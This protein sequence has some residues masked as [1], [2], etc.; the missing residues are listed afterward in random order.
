MIK[1]EADACKGELDITALGPLTNIA[2]A[3][4][5]EIKK[6]IKSITIMGGSA[7]AGNVTPNAEFN[8][9]TDPDSCDIVFRSGVPESGC[10]GL[11]GLPAVLLAVRNWSR[12]QNIREW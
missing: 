5:P 1:E 12:L 10:A 4:Y 11:T 7:Y 6:E 9:W 2:T 3:R 8:I